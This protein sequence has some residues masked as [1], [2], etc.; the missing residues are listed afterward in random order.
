MEHAIARLDGQERRALRRP[1]RLTAAIKDTVLEEHVSATP[2]TQDV[3]VQSS[4]AP[5]PALV[6][7]HVSTLPAFAMPDGLEK[8]ARFVLVPMTVL[9]REFATMPL[10]IVS[11]ALPEQIV[12]SAHAPTSAQETESVLIGHACATAVSW[13]QIAP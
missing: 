5:T 9:R 1:A 10:A 12:Q 6:P 2:N 7:V 11:L 8:T 3:I 4:N 13:E